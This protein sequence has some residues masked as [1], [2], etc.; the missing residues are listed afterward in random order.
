MLYNIIT[1]TLRVLFAGLILFQPK[2]SSIR[3]PNLVELIITSVYRRNVCRK[4]YLN[5]RFTLSSLYDFT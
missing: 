5:R 2:L 3:L 4:K 1:I